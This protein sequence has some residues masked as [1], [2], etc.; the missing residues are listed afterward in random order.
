MAFEDF[1]N[2]LAVRMGCGAD[3][4]WLYDIPDDI[5]LDAMQAADLLEGLLTLGIPL[6]EAECIDRSWDPESSDWGRP[7][8]R[9][10]QVINLRVADES[11]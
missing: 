1:E 4:V 3:E 5:Y 7:Y 10:D 8:Y 11:M 6:D 9:P 2:A